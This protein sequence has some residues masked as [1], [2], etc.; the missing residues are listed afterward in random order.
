MQTLELRG[1]GRQRGQ[2]HGEALR[3]MVHEH[4]E[5]WK[6]ALV[7]DLVVEPDRYVDEFLADT[8]FLSAASRLTPDLLDEVRGIHE[9]AAT[10]W[11]YTLVRQLSDEEPWYRRARRLGTWPGRPALPERDPDAG[12]YGG[13]VRD[14]G[15]SSI[16]GRVEAGIV[17]AQNMDTPTWY[18]GH[19]VLL[20]VIDPDTGIE[21]LVFTVAGKISLAGMNNCGLA[22]TCNTLSQ[23]DYDPRGLAEDFVV[24]GYLAQ[25]N[26]QAGLEFLRTIPHASGQNYTV[27]GSDGSVLNLECS[28]AGVVSWRPWAGAD[29]VFHTNHPLAS[30]DQAIYRAEMDR[31]TPGRRARLTTTTS[32][33]R[34]AEL[35]RWVG[36]P[37]KPLTLDRIRAALS[38][39]SGPVC[40]EGEFEGFRDGYT[41]GCLIMRPGD[42]GDM[43]VSPGPPSRVPFQRFAFD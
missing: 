13:A 19:Q 11:R 2:A 39:S 3:A 14:K 22:M 23:L 1:K 17:I 29:R 41:L 36:D 38:S 8:D 9:G 16:G 21:A 28:R 15:C 12:L 6:Q 30:D 4:L 43:L 27:P 33:G 35:Q 32:Q 37:E 5:R 31:L 10:D 40:R 7:D 26:V 18:D 20:K 42:P 25:P 34:L 24:R